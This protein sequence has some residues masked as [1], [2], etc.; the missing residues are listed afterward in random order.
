MAN[1]EIYKGQESNFNVLDIVGNGS[2]IIYS[3]SNSNFKNKIERKAKFPG[4]A[5]TS[6]SGVRFILLSTIINLNK[7]YEITIFRHWINYYK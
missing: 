7:I 2:I 1:P 6:I 5:L 4:P 3:N